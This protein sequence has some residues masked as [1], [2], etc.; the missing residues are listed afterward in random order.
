MISVIVPV[1][2]SEMYLRECLDSVLRQTYQDFE[3]LLIDDGSNDGSGRICEEYALKD[4]RFFVI[5]KQNSG[6]SSSR[7]FGL[8]KAKGEYI[9]FVDSDDVLVDSYLEKLYQGILV[10]D[11][12][13][14]L[15]KYSRINGD[16]VIPQEEKYLK[17]YINDKG[18]DAYFNS[19]FVHYIT[20]L[21][22]DNASYLAGSSWRMLFRKECFSYPFPE[23]VSVAEDFLFVMRNFA[24]VNRI[25]VVDETLYFYRVNHASVM[26][27]YRRDFLKNQQV[28]LREFEDFL[29]GLKLADKIKTEEIILAQKALSSAFLFGNEIRFRKQ[30]EDFKGN[31]E[32]LKEDELYSY[33]I[34]KNVLK[35]KNK[36]MKV[37]Y[38]GVW[39]LVKTGIYKLL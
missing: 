38:L 22:K 5:H 16:T 6:V 24:V 12:D 25:N 26:S 23:D 39:L 32:K 28:F 20:V 3:V 2:N 8:T 19:F 13:V 35:I 4:N 27:N 17:T 37:K 1:Y 34:F 10:G 15:C 21:C 18:V 9:A 14:C 30:V 36:T 31:I 11:A 33:L 29:R 7:N